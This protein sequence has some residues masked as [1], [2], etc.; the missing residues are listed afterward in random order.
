VAIALQVILSFGHAHRNEGVGRLVRA[1]A[2]HAQTVAERG[3]PAAPPAGPA[4]EYCA[5]CAVI[6]MGA[7][8]VPPEAPISGAPVLAGGTRLASPAE[9]AAGTLANQLFQARAPPSA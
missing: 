5:I 7:A 9:A 1:A 3:T 4:I 2:L 8:T 6:K